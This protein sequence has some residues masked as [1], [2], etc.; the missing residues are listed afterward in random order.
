MSAAGERGPYGVWTR[1]LCTGLLA[2]VCVAAVHLSTGRLG[3][4]GTG[5]GTGKGGSPAERVDWE[6]AVRSPHPPRALTTRADLTVGPGTWRAT[7]R[8]TLLLHPGDPLLSVI[9]EGRTAAG[10]AR[11]DD[12]LAGDVRYVA[13][14]GLR[15]DGGTA[16]RL[17]AP[18]VTQDGPRERAVV[19]WTLEE[20]CRRPCA[21]D[22]D[23]RFTVRPAETPRPSG[24]RWTLDVR[25]HGTDTGIT[26][27]TGA[28]PIR[29]TPGR[30]VL[31]PLDAAG[32]TSVVFRAAG[33]RDLGFLPEPSAETGPRFTPSFTEPVPVTLGIVLGFLLIGVGAAYGLRSFDALGTD[34]RRPAVSTPLWI[35]TLLGILF[36]VV[37]WESPRLTD[38][39]A[40]SAVA[41]ALITW[42]GV[43]VP[44]GLL[45][46]LPALYNVLKRPGEPVQEVLHRRAFLALGAVTG[47][48]VA[49]EAAL[50]LTYGSGGVSPPEAVG[51]PLLAVAAA[52]AVPLVAPVGFREPYLWSAIGV[53]AA[54]AACVVT[55][56]GRLIAAEGGDSPTSEAL[57]LIGLGLL[58]W[59]ALTRA[60][61]LLGAR[62]RLWLLAAGVTALLMYLPVDVT[63]AFGTPETVLASTPHPRLFEATL[64]DIAFH[65]AGA[66]MVVAIAV[67]VRGR[68]HSSRLP[69][70]LTGHARTMEKERAAAL[71]VAFVVLTVNPVV[72]AEHSNVT[73]VLPVAAALLGFSLLLRGE[74]RRVEGRRLAAV[75]RTEYA[76]VVRRYAR[77]A[78]LQSAQRPMFLKARDGLAD[79][80]LALDRFDEDWRRLGGGEAPPPL[81][82]GGARSPWRNGVHGAL[83]AFLLALPVMAIEWYSVRRLLPELTLGQLLALA[84]HTLRWS[85][86][87]AF[88]GYFSTRLPGRTPVM[89]AQ[90]LLAALL[91]PELLLLFYPY[92]RQVTD[93]GLASGLRVGWLIVFC[94]VLGMYWE[95]RLVARAGVQWRLVRSFRSWA[96]LTAPVT[97][98]VVAAATAVAT[99]LAGAAAVSMTQQPTDGGSLQQQSSYSSGP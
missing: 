34:G 85:A 66:F 22:G 33:T 76:A 92:S 13:G 91:V 10:A 11:L 2:L 51:G 3:H 44:V 6:R 82:T 45:Y 67:M 36:A 46:L 97:A 19:A 96:S 27:V 59:P 40:R 89:K 64:V 57:L 68:W 9:R 32:A 26:G 83:V 55:G 75:D 90:F 30:A 73:D 38:D 37:A 62:G 53:V 1:W 60:T 4:D 23:F 42:W 16:R 18:E 77:W 12:R 8:H 94:L 78:L 7:V 15:T 20:T 81:S 52:A 79:G 72:A 65:A 54:V 61:L 84:E 50:V 80:S 48:G 39:A 49:V 28:R 74:E 58:W 98:V 21:W 17:T 25:V 41:T 70:P 43:A 71:G 93:L 29:Q 63:R 87:G 86:Y 95:W 69:M 56:W 31:A 88:Y 24:T 99:V 35:F 47:L 14:E 5:T